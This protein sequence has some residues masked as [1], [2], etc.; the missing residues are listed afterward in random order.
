MPRL[1]PEAIAGILER[2]VLE[3]LG[4]QPDTVPPR[5]QTRAVAR[6]EVREPA[7]EPDVTVEPQSAAHRMDHPL[8]AT[9]E[10][11]PVEQQR[12]RVARRRDGRQRRVAAP[13]HRQLICPS[14]VAGAT[15]AT[16][17]L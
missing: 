15:G 13:A 9:P 17:P 5:E 6:D 4:R 3:P 11:A 2:M 1:A 14:V 8:A 7:A 10:L 12:R 16:V